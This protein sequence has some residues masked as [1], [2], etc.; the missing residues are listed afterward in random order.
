MVL[1]QIIT[2]TTIPT[3]GF[4]TH[5]LLKLFDQYKVELGHVIIKTIL[6]D[7]NRREPQLPQ[8]QD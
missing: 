8:F 7:L 1:I 3:A 4:L 2:T 5:F 6:V